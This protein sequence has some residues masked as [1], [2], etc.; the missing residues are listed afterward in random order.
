M[1]GS[2]DAPKSLMKAWTNKLCF[3]EAG[4]LELLSVFELLDNRL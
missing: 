1:R 3:I 2:S 4:M